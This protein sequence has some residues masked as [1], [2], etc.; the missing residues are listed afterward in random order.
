M[1]RAKCLESLMVGDEDAESQTLSNM[2][3][4]NA[5][6]VCSLKINKRKTLGFDVHWRYNE[7]TV[8]ELHMHFKYNK[9]RATLLLDV[10]L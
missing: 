6:T 10:Y 3:V 4:D 1:P 7:D 5:R 2:S 9:G 8:P